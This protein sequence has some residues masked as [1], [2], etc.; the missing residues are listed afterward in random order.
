MPTGRTPGPTCSIASCKVETAHRLIALPDTDGV[1]HS[2][3][4]K[5]GHASLPAEP[6]GLQNWTGLRLLC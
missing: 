6:L 3:I 2:D 4:S 1:D 5:T